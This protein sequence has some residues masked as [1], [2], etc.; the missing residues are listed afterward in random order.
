MMRSHRGTR[1]RRRESTQSHLGQCVEYAVGV[2]EKKKGKKDKKK[3]LGK[4]YFRLDVSC[5]LGYCVHGLR[6]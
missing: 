5:S 1:A 4:M 3:A 6:D 2:K